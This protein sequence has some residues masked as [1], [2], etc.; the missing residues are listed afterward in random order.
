[1][2]TLTPLE[3]SQQALVF[4]V[5]GGQDAAAMMDAMEEKYRETLEVE[6]QVDEG[7]YDDSTF[8]EGIGA[9]LLETSLG[10]VS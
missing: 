9:P 8:P 10:V 1:M 5:D 7:A 6:Q 4:Y 3:L 2:T